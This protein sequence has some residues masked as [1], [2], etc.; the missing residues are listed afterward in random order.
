MPKLKDIFKKKDIKK[1]KNDEQLKQQIAKQI[2][3]EDMND[4]GQ[5][6]EHF[7]RKKLNGKIE[8]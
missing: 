6:F 7:N 4:D 2:A 8:K 1:V 5:I 3:L